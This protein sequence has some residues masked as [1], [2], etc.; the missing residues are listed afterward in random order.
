MS[1]PNILPV[2]TEQQE[3][4]L[5]P[6]LFEFPYKQ[7]SSY[8]PIEFSDLPP[9]RRLS[10]EKMVSKSGMRL[11]QAICLRTVLL[12]NAAPYRYHGSEQ[13]QLLAATQFEAA[14]ARCLAACDVR[15]VTQDQQLAR[16]R[17]QGVQGRP[18]PDF[19]FE[20]HPVVI[21]GT[22][23]RWV[24]VKM[25]YGA[26]ATD[27]KDWAVHLK[28]VK[29]TIRYRN[30]LGPG[31]VVFLHGYSASMRAWV[32]PDVLLLDGACVDPAA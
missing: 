14:V 26:A 8:E 18:T 6:Y 31:A 7:W 19:L 2:P 30:E 3:N 10:I 32:P 12:K 21:N 17:A 22:H 9:G 25:F 13:G 28:A 23:V 11:T 4:A 15:F 5:R 29:Q 27:V 24:E 16:L 1:W 20:E